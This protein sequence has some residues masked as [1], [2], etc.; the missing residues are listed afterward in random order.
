MPVNPPPEPE[1]LK[2]TAQG[3]H[4][5][6]CTKLGAPEI[7]KQLCTEMGG[8]FAGGMPPKDFLKIFMRGDTKKRLSSI[9]SVDFSEVAAAPS[10]PKMYGPL[11]NA[12]NTHRLCQGV[13][14]KDISGRAQS[15]TKLKPD[16]GGFEGNEMQLYI[17]LKSS[18][19]QDAFH[20]SHNPDDR[21]EKQTDESSKHRGQ[22]IHYAAEQM[23]VQHRVSLLTISMTGRIARFIRWDRSGAIVTK[24]FDYVDSPHLLAEF[25][26]RFSRLNAAQRGFD[27]TVTPADQHEIASLSS[28]LERYAD[29]FGKRLP[30]QLEEDQAG[31]QRAYKI[32]AIIGN[33]TRTTLVVGKPFCQP[34]SP[35]GRATRGYI[36]WDIVQ[37]K[38]VFLKDTWRVV[39][40]GSLSEGEAYEHLKG[41]DLIH[42]AL[43]VGTSSSLTYALL[44]KGLHVQGHWQFASISLLGDPHK[45]HEVYDDVESCYWVLLYFSLHF[46]SHQT[47][48]FSMTLFDQSEEKPCDQC[49]LMHTYGG[50]MKLQ[51]AFRR[52]FGNVEFACGPLNGLIQELTERVR[53]RAPRTEQA[54]SNPTIIGAYKQHE[55]ES[56]EVQSYIQLFD[57]ALSEDGW[58]VEDAV[59]DQLP[60]KSALQISQAHEKARSASFSNISLAAKVGQKSQSLSS[61][62][63]RIAM[64]SNSLS[65]TARATNY[66]P[67]AS[68]RTRPLPNTRSRT[69]MIPMAPPP[70]P[71]IFGEHPTNASRSSLA[72]PF[73]H[74][75]HMG[76]EQWSPR[77]LKRPR[78][79]DEIE[80]V[81]PMKHP[82]IGIHR[83][84]S[85]SSPKRTTSKSEL[86]R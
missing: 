34:L 47:Q 20:D 27:T 74:H 36:A 16:I 11:I 17:E 77:N 56:E 41:H 75:P 53:L 12:I 30:T 64:R 10:E 22:I 86:H 29:L 4:H 6:G 45:P 68:R 51:A 8:S 58:L 69:S 37:G 65:S 3:L 9:P 59:E 84:G 54:I 14:F 1:P 62:I 25:L 67:S 78:D 48:H 23:A 32:P 5:Y 21:I 80:E 2:A 72:V 46:I 55:S 44:T 18:E 38:L 66:N 15:G 70:L 52:G 60:P 63:A 85:R 19:R 35:C 57:T 82:R 50:S 24:A 83:T 13:T 76:T 49:D 40:P 31:Q 73:T 7:R 39:S 79:E 42:I 81:L 26:I 28:A 43:Y 61:T 71:V 33:G